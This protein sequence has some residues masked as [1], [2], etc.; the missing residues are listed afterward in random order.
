MIALRIKGRR[1]CFTRPENKVERMTYPVIT[2]SAA[3][4]VLG[5]IHAKPEMIWKITSIRLLAPIR[6]ET[7][8]LNELKHPR[9]IDITKGRTQ[10]RSRILRDVDYII[11]AKAYCLNDDEPA[12]HEAIFLRRL[13]KGDYHHQPS[14][15]LSQYLA[16]VYPVDEI[17]DSPIQGEIEL[18][19]MFH[20]LNWKTNERRFYDV[21]MVDGLIEVPDLWGRC[22]E[23]RRPASCQSSKS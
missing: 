21:Y 1:A 17:P 18:G 14:L 22:E 13:I 16:D 7:W 12:K 9:Q 2:P 15:G 23:L 8:M 11:E 19:T 3:Q 20:S 10:R 5:S 6:Y 4:G